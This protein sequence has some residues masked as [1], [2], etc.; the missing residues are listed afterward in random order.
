MPDD[1]SKLINLDLLSRYNGKADTRET[2][3]IKALPIVSKSDFLRS[4]FAANRDGKIYGVKF[5]YSNTD[6]IQAESGVKYGANEGLV[7]NPSTRTIQGRDDYRNLN[8]FKSIDANVHY[9]TDGE[10]VVDAIHGEEG[11]SYTGKVDVVCIFA[12]VYERVYVATE[13]VNS[14]ETKYLYI[15]WTD[16][17]RDGFTL[18]ILCKDQQ[19]KNRGW[20]CITKFMSALIDNAPYSSAGLYPWLAAPCYNTCVDK[21]HARSS[22]MT[23]M[24][25][26]QFCMIQRIFMMKYGHT[27]YDSKL[28]GLF[29]YNYTNYAIQANTTNKNYIIGLTTN[30][31][32]LYA[33]TRIGIG[34]GT[35]TAASRS[36]CANVEITEKDANI[37]VF[38]NINANLVITPE[39]VTVTTQIPDIVIHTPSETTTDLV[40]VIYDSADAGVAEITYDD[41]GET[42]T[43]YLKVVEDTGVYKL[44]VFDENDQEVGISSA[45]GLATCT[46]LKLSK[47]VTVTTS[48]TYET[49]IY[50]TGYSLEI[51]GR[52]GCYEIGSF[53]SDQRHPSVMSG[54]ELFQGA[55]DV[56][57]NAVFNYNAD[58]SCK[59]LVMNNLTQ[60]TKTTAT[61]TSSYTNVG[62]MTHTT[63]GS[64]WK[65]ARDI[66]YDL[67]NGAC[68]MDLDGGSST[69]GLCDATY[70]LGN[71][72]SGLYE[73]L[74]FGNLLDGAPYGPFCLSANRA[75]SDSSWSIGAR[76][77]FCGL[78]LI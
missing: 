67:V 51:L 56:I 26:S 44:V 75:L 2:N 58:T 68:V 22:Y 65:Y 60:V 29:L 28:G 27:N 19:G 49:A 48:N 78:P 10:I 38:T 76:A 15:E 62:N 40:D 45:A 63:T 11:F 52:D 59:V 31:N 37:R 7:V 70:Y 25:M 23:A 12:P 64:G 72:K 3:K 73:V 34:T 36:V 71:Q 46:L 1:F 66:H 35:R 57:G 33:T 17:P 39:G 32:N 53:V 16:T 21:Y 42:K 4:Y 61:I 43:G 13:T 8:L 54:I 5:A 14:V 30:T 55:W 6:V 50:E 9:D 24:T 47:T 18:N 41:N 20:Y 69:N 74:A 77:A